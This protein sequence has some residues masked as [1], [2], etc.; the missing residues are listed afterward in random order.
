VANVVDGKVT[1]SERSGRVAKAKGLWE[2]PVVLPSK[3]DSQGL[4]F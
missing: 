2:E 1:L 3:L 4:V